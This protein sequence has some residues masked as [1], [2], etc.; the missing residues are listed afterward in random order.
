MADQVSS[1]RISDVDF[2]KLAAEGE[3][4]L[5]RYF[6]DT[7]VF[8]R[9]RSG[10][11]AYV[12]GRKGSGKTAIFRESD[13]TRIGHPVIKLDFE[14]YSW[15][16]HLKIKEEGVFEEAAYVASWKF[17][18]LI[19]VCRHWYT[20]AP[21]EIAEKALNYI[22]QIYGNDDPSKMQTLFDEFR[23]IRKL[24]LPAY[25]G[26]G[27]VELSGK[28]EGAM[29][30]KS[31]SV[32]NDKL[33]KF[34]ARHFVDSPFSILADRLD[35]GW[36]GSMESK[37]LLAGAIKAARAIGIDAGKPHHAAPVIVF[38]RSDI[39]DQLQFNDKNKIQSDIEYLNWEERDLERVITA[40][41][42]AS[43]HCGLEQAWAAVF[44][45]DEMRQRMSA[46]SYILRRTMLRPRD[47]IAFCN[48][49][50]DAAQRGG[51]ALVEKDDIYE[52]ERQYSKHMYDELDD[53]AHKQTPQFRDIMQILRDVNLH[54][55]TFA[56][57]E[58][59]CRARNPDVADGDVREQLKILFD[60]SVVGVQRRGGAAAGTQFVFLYNDRLLE[61]NF[62]AEMLVHPSLRKHMNIKEARRTR[63]EETSP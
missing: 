50:K 52:A 5:T 1:V 54:R 9:L 31:V 60:Y 44:S 53:E 37:H 3:H 40:R 42:D 46:K 18:F 51:H 57:W 59:A 41:I 61:P 2:G 16:A 4:N 33:S 6:V 34:V 62:S 63:E 35:E 39:F 22:V 47:V 26:G 11:K 7:G 45:Q 28:D 13:E 49:C 30:A 12:I 20:N 21:K 14:D 36:D 55:F 29:L 19:N 43:L 32:W 24:E 10:Q 17:S 8:E 38:L 56:D 23:R 25:L 48:A 15:P 58:T 27:G